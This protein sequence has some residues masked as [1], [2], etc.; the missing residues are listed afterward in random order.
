VVAAN[1]ALA[2]GQDPSASVSAARSAAAED[3]MRSLR[4]SQHVTLVRPA[5]RLMRVA[6][7][8]QMLVT[9]D[10]G[11]APAATQV[12]LAPAA[13]EPPVAAGRDSASA[14]AADSRFALFRALFALMDEAAPEAATEAAMPMQLADAAPTS[15]A[16]PFGFFPD[17]DD[18][19]TP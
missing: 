1:L 18:F 11:A 8:V 13:L 5:G 6:P 15:Q 19:T 12:S 9:G 10:T 3:P 4:V 17:V 16:S 2:R 14:G 7:G